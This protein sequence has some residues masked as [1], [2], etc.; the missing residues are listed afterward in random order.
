MS[1]VS[2]PRGVNPFGGNFAAAGAL[3]K[4]ALFGGYNGTPVYG[5]VKAG[6]NQKF[7]A[8]IVES[9]CIAF[10]TG[11]LREGASVPLNGIVNEIESW[12]IKYN[13]KTVID[14]APVNDAIIPAQYA[15]LINGVYQI[16]IPFVAGPGGGGGG[17]LHPRVSL[18]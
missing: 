7:F 16:S 10:Y 5:A 2:Y 15:K 11:G 3:F 1:A 12:L 17:T 13:L 14:G 18:V 9:H 8:P 6:A 4:A